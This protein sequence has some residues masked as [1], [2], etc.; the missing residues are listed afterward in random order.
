MKKYLSYFSVLIMLAAC[1]GQPKDFTAGADVRIYPDFKDI[2][3][4][5]NIAPVNFMIEDSAIKYYTILE[6][7]DLKVKISGRKVCIPIRKWK[8]L[9]SKDRITVTV[10]EKSIDGW[11]KMKPFTIDV[12][13]EID[14]YLT[15]RI[16][17]PSFESYQNLSIRQR[18][19]T[20]FKE[21]TVYSNS[22]V[23]SGTT[24]QCINCHSF[25]NWRTDD[26]QFHIRQ[27]LGGTVLF[28]KGRLSKLNLKTEQTISAGVYP[29]WHPTHDYIAYSTNKTFQNVHTINTNRVEVFDDESDLILYNLTNNSI[30][31]IENDSTELEC[32]PNWAPDGRTLYYVSAHIG[33][34]KQFKSNGGAASNLNIRYNLFSKAFDPDTRTWSKKTI[35]IRADSLQKSITLP[36]V[37]PDGRWLMFTMG[38]QGV[39]HIWHKDSELYLMD[40]NDNSYRCLNEINS[41]NV[42]SYHSWSSN[43]KWV[44]FSSRR[45]DGFYTR[46]YLAYMYENGFFSKPFPLPQRDPEFS[47]KFLYSFNIPEFTIEP[48]KI[49]AKKLASFI[50]KNDALPVSFEQKKDNE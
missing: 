23:A 46:L 39:F 8:R 3:I 22:M 14:P 2:T 30:S 38:N 26:M 15:Y 12:S 10:F 50:K 1:Y 13:D 6:S 29:S 7:G 45:E 9:T 25:K 31:I 40:L 5:S 27:F 19:I 20:S 4:P 43:G 49:S 42:E 33:D 24:T 21:R 34:P 17:P 11:K 32:F 36:R 41:P 47:N 37:S 44:V 18:N 16:I 35:V 28:T 48:V